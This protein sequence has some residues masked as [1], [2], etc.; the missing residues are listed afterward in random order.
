MDRA[1]VEDRIVSDFTYHTRRIIDEQVFL[2]RFK[3]AVKTKKT[4]GRIQNY[5]AYC[6]AHDTHHR[7]LA[8]GVCQDGR[9]LVHCYAGCSAADIMG[10]VGMSVSDLYPDGAMGQSCAPVPAPVETRV[11]DEVLKIAK[12]TRDSGGKLSKED[13]LR[14]RKAWVAAKKDQSW[15]KG[16]AA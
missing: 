12:L 9:Y 1:G 5:L 8:I 13:L 15:P 16:S 10:A 7:S 6:P 3:G 2:S 11:N 14:E 4:G